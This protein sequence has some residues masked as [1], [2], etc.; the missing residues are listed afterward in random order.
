MRENSIHVIMKVSFGMA[1]VV[2]IKVCVFIV[3]S[4]I[5]FFKRFVVFKM[6]NWCHNASDKTN[7]S[8]RIN[9]TNESYTING[10]WTTGMAWGMDNWDGRKKKVE[11]KR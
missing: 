8:Y 6:M 5:L 1:C 3:N 9:K 10:R 2:G 4:F 11:E 7:E